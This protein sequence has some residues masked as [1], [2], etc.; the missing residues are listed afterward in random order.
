MCCKRGRKALARSPDKI[1]MPHILTT[2]QAKLEGALLHLQP[3]PSML[4]SSGWPVWTCHHRGDGWG[5]KGWGCPTMW[6]N[7]PTKWW[8]YT[9]KSGPSEVFTVAMVWHPYR[10]PNAH[11]D[12]YGSRAL[13]TLPSLSIFCH[14]WK[15]TGGLDGT[16]RDIGGFP[17]LWE[18]LTQ[19]SWVMS[20]SVSLSKRHLESWRV[21]NKF[22]VDL[23]SSGA[24]D[25]MGWQDGT[26]GWGV[27]PTLLKLILNIY[28]H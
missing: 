19:G 22:A 21:R 20:Y 7:Y 3:C 26:A 2:E 25:A 28:R 10:G 18:Q 13:S 12:P 11:G 15:A 4:M 14:T 17:P 24:H 1:K 27:F 8:G 23:E 9:T 6:W 16:Q 5:R